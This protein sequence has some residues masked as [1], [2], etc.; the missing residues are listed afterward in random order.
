[1]T[2][3]NAASATK[4][5][6]GEV[7]L[8]YVHL[9]EPYA[10]NADQEPKYSV[11]LLIPKEDKATLSK[12]R[13]AQAAAL[14]AGLASKFNGKKP[15]NLKNTLR[16]GDEE[17]DL[18]KNPEY[19]GHY[20]MNVNSKT[21]PGIVDRSVKPIEDSSEVYSGCYARVSI[22]A[23]AYNTSGN[24]GISFG[25]NH[26]QKLR[27]GEFLGGRSKAEDDFDEVEPDDGDLFGDGDD[28]GLI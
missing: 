17:M 9:W 14:E 13:K 4:V 2:D 8:S 20:F 1:M 3:K 7:R 22:N 16:D 23:F 24:K 5:V 18:E 25:L 10:Q 6:T 12:I 26:V 28:S 27:D 11:A 15:P 21:K 19:A